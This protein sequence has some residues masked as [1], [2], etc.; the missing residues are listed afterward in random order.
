MP[1]C[2]QKTGF[3]TTQETTGRTRNQN[4]QQDDTNPQPRGGDSVLVVVQVDVLNTD[5]LVRH[6]HFDDR[7]LAPLGLVLVDPLAPVPL[8]DDSQNT[9]LD[10]FDVLDP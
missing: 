10:P 3:A 1:N 8:V 2:N 6:R 9:L 7:R 5:T 4:H